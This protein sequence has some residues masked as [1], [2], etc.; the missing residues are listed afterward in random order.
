[1]IIIHIIVHIL[2]LVK[3]V[4]S[5]FSF[6]ISLKTTKISIRRP[7]SMPAKPSFILSLIIGVYLVVGL[8]YAGLTPPWQAPDEPAHYNYVRYVAETWSLPVL[9]SG[10]YD[11]A[12]LNRLK[13]EKFPPT[14]SIEAICYEHYQPPLYYLLAG[15][16]FAATQG[17]LLALRL[18]SV[19]LG[20]A[21]LFFVYK[22]VC[23]FMAQPAVALGT[24]AFVAFVPMHLTM[25]ASVNNDSLAELLFI[26]LIFLLLRWLLQARPSGK[27]ISVMVGVVLGLILVTKVTIYISLPLVALALFLRDRTGPGLLKN[28][29]R[30][31]LPALLVAL[32]FYIRNSLVYGGFDL[33]G[34]RRHDAVVV[35]QLRTADYLAEVGWGA[36]LNNLGRTTF[37]SFWGQFGWLAVP[38]DSRVYLALTIVQVVVCCGLLLWLWKS[39][40][41]DASDRQALWVMLAV[42]VLAG[43][44]FIGLNLSFVQFQGRY[45]FTALMPIGLFFTLGLYEALRRRWALGVSAV[46]AGLVVWIGVSS[47]LG[48]ALDKW[49]LLIAGLALATAFL[50]RWLPGED[51][52]LFVAA[53]YSGLAALATASVWWFIIPNL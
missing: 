22:T 39:P 6:A 38:M 47:A 48:G 16:V 40:P 18:F 51:P 52:A 11:E 27:P 53:F 46:L 4:L 33:L 20:A 29:L 49:G 32:P 41:E 7:N 36:Y 30:L 15:P 34:L 45:L 24:T 44:V 21:S 9:A 25:L 19:I 35:G 2:I 5:A 50:R 23:L 8:L 26:L 10:C 37:H 1:L 42:I 17:S 3:E 43:G 12:Y 28:G 13:S 14:L 31:F